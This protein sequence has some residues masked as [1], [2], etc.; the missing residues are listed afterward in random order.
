MVKYRRRLAFTVIYTGGINPFCGGHYGDRL[1]RLPSMISR[2]PRFSARSWMDSRTNSGSGLQTLWTFEFDGVRCKRQ[3]SGRKPDYRFELRH[4]YEEPF[5][6][7]VFGEVFQTFPLYVYTGNTDQTNDT[8][9]T[10]V[11]VS[12]EFDEKRISGERFGFSFSNLRNLQTAEGNMTVKGN[13]VTSG[14]GST[15]QVYRYESTD[16]CYF[17][18]VSSSNY[19]ILYDESE[20]SCTESASMWTN[21][22]QTFY[23]Y[24]SDVPFGS[25]FVANVQYDAKG[26]SA[27]IIGC[28]G[29]VQ[30]RSAGHQKTTKLLKPKSN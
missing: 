12:L 1:V 28:G 20:K 23:T 19:T 14:I 22:S 6:G 9:S 8:Y 25:V 3:L 10:V 17:R 26:H 7:F 24:E 13:L 29:V 11:N 27:C 18:N 15:Q 21:K 16:G 4:I 5:F 30:K 2:S